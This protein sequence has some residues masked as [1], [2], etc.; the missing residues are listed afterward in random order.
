MFSDGGFAVSEMSTGPGSVESS[1]RKAQEIR[2]QKIRE[3][4]SSW[5][6]RYIEGF[7]APECGSGT[8]TDALG[9]VGEIVCEMYH[10]EC[11]RQDLIYAKWKDGGTSKSNGV[12]LLFEDAGRILSVECKHVH[13]PRSVGDES[14]LL[15]AIKTGM[16]EHAGY[17]TKAFLAERYRIM[18]KR[19][20]ELQAEGSDASQTRRKIRVVKSALGGEFDSQVD[21][22]ADRERACAA[23]YAKLGSRVAEA[24]PAGSGVRALLLLVHKLHEAA[25][26]A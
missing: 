2:L 25:E 26:A 24:R 22:A 3:G 8:D 7:R 23:D 16:R 9:L 20:R 1:L 5:G 19:V 18:S 13:S 17:R 15:A 11:K 21:L 4:R 12:D 6:R 10:E 14:R